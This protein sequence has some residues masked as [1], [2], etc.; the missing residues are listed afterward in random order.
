MDILE[1]YAGFVPGVI[2][3]LVMTPILGPRVGSWVA[4]GRVLGSALVLAIGVVLSATITPSDDALLRGFTSAGTCDLARTGLPS[5]NQLRVSSEIELNILLFL[6]LGMAIGVLPPGRAERLVIIGF[7][8][9]FAIEAVQLVVVLLGRECQSGDV[10]DNVTGFALGIVAGGAFRLGRAV[11]RNDDWRDALRRSRPGIR[12]ASAALAGGLLVTSSLLTAT[13]PADQ[14]QVAAPT[15]TPV[16]TA[17]P[18]P[19]ESIRVQ[20]VAALLQ[21]LADPRLREIVVADGVYRVAPAGRQATDS[22]WIGEAFAGRTRPITV[23][24]ETPG[25]VT[26][27]GGGAD[28]FG[29]VWF[30]DGAHDQTWEGFT[31]ANGSATSTGVIMFG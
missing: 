3:T 2:A 30:V 21:A 11:A 6:P 5:L 17:T 7:A 14:G 18:G 13:P 8:L 1:P 31:F 12:V 4:G 9:P 19:G 25:G 29:G 28:A 23:R 27:D 26:F 15:S 16:P 24:A 10:I 22:L 20:S